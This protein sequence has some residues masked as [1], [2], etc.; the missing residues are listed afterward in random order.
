MFSFHG[1]LQLD[2]ETL[3]LRE[4]SG[5]MA[6]F[7]DANNRQFNFTRDI[8]T[9]VDAF[10]VEGN[11]VNISNNGENTVLSATPGPSSA[12]SDHGPQYRSCSLPSQNFQPTPR[13][14]VPSRPIF[15]SASSKKGS[16]SSLNLKIIQATVPKTTL[17]AADGKPDAELTFLKTGQMFTQ[18]TDATATVPHLLYIIRDKWGPGYVLVT[19]DGLKIE[20]SDG[21]RGQ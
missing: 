4:V 6:F 13:V 10:Y 5:R 12:A 11:R 8:G 3:Y 19:K 2:V 9:I 21:T 14:A 17:A 16:G 15:T 1:H 18:I 7:P 20:D